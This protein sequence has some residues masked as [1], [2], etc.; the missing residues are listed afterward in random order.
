MMKMPEFMR[1]KKWWMA[2]LGAFVPLAN[3][4]FGWGL[5]VEQVAT[6]VLPFVAYIAGQ[7]L[8]DFGKHA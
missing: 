1:S 2:I 7:G 4:V 3:E 6:V 5:S 8:A